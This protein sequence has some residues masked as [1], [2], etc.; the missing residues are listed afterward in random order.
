MMKIV[1]VGFMGSG[2]STVGKIL[3]EKLSVP[4]VD[5]DSVVV[6]RAGM[7]IP[8]IFR[9]KGESEFRKIER[10]AL[11]SELLKEGSFVLSTGGG[12]PAYSDNMEIINR[13]ALS[14]FLYADFETLYGRISEDRNRPLTAL[15]KEELERLYTDRLPFYKKARFTVNTEGKTPEEVAEEIISLL[16]GGRDRAIP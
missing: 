6:E 7:S 9:K 2:K 13:F 15:K 8:E 1:L 14:F 16:S 10:E 12:A 5:L 3:S 11:I 4:F